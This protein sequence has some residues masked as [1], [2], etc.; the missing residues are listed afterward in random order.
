MRN[1]LLTLSLLFACATSTLGQ[2]LL[3]RQSVDGYKGAGEITAFS[4]SRVFLQLNKD[5]EWPRQIEWEIRKGNQLFC[6]VRFNKVGWQYVTG[7]D[8]CGI[9]WTSIVIQDYR[10]RLR[11]IDYLPGAA[12][13]FPAIE[14]STA[15]LLSR[16]STIGSTSDSLGTPQQEIQSMGRAPAVA[17]DPET[18]KDQLELPTT[19]TSQSG[20]MVDRIQSDMALLEG[21]QKAPKT[22]P[23]ESAQPLSA[24]A[25]TVFM[26][27]DPLV[28][29]KERIENPVP[30][31][32]LMPSIRAEEIDSWQSSSP[33]LEPPS[34]TDE[35]APDSSVILSRQPEYVFTVPIYQPRRRWLARR[36]TETNH[37]DD[38]VTAEALF[39]SPSETLDL[40]NP[41][42]SLDRLTQ[43][44]NEKVKSHDASEDLAQAITSQN[45]TTLY[46]QIAPFISVASFETLDYTLEVLQG[47]QCPEGCII[48]RSAKG[49]YYRIGFYPD[50]TEIM[51]TLQ[52]IRKKYPDAW[53]VK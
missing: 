19:M 38:S 31:S 23:T 40:S 34:L 22:T 50:P 17:N 20:P 49:L 12:D 43:G 9:D 15:L 16:S 24:N 41:L 30:D 7:I 42:L 25:A 10:H 5:G 33:D 36:N 27:E 13:V 32:L 4:S 48:V 53:L 21:V 46:E 3:L 39:S 44:Q 8:T 52:Q 47:F 37:V 14:A 29:Q 18:K 2:Q 1:F 11:V 51:I 26:P 45:D 28:D 6:A 35:D